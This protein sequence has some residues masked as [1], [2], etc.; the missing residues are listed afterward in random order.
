MPAEDPP[1]TMPA[2]DRVRLCRLLPILAVVLGMAVVFLS[3]LNHAL[4][5]ETLVRHRA[6]IDALIQANVPMAIAG[7]ILLYVLV[8]SLSVPG[9]ACL[10]ISGGIMFGAIAGGLAAVV[11]GTAGAVVIFLIARSACREFVVRRAG[12]LSARL[13][14][15]FHADAFSYLLFLRLVPA[16]PFWLVN[17]AAALVGVELRTFFAATALGVIPGTFAFAVIGAGLDSVIAA[18]E[19]LYRHC[20]AAG[21]SDC[22]L[23]FSWRAV[24]TPELMAALAALGVVVLIPVIMRHLRAGRPAAKGGDSII[25]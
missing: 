5:L 1:A 3:G 12:G 24:V 16:F 15:G 7:F 23:N 17:L 18:Q 6:A 25:A 13:A 8:V 10:T 20:L 14:A 9:A 19:A 2:A 4:S 11:G 21:G 22:R